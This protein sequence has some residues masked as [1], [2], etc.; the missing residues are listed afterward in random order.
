MKR[1]EHSA[2]REKAPPNGINRLTTGR[3]RQTRKKKSGVSLTPQVLECLR[4][5][6]KKKERPWAGGGS[7]RLEWKGKK[8]KKDS[9]KSNTE[10]RRAHFIK[11][12]H[13]SSPY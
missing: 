9:Y 2:G 1:E 13:Y 12:I 6:K 4:E 3:G 11:T 7:R 8:E 10:K 5:E